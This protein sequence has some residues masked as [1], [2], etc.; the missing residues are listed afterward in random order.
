MEAQEKTKPASKKAEG[1]PILQKKVRKEQIQ[2]LYVNLALNPGG[3]KLPLDIG[4]RNK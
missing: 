3:K 2:E 4:V 1:V